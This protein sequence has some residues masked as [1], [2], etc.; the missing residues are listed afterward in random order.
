[1]QILVD[2]KAVSSLG[3]HVDLSR[4]LPPDMTL[5][6]AIS[7]SPEPGASPSPEA[8]PQPSASAASPAAKDATPPR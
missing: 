5:L 4:P 3:G 2:D 1:V 7:A 8:P 6:A